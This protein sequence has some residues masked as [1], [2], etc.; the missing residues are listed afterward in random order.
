M[1]GKVGGAGDAGGAGDSGGYGGGDG[2]SGANGGK[3]F[4]SGSGGVGRTGGGLAVASL[5]RRRGMPKC[6]ASLISSF[7]SSR[8]PQCCHSCFP[9]STVSTASVKVSMATETASDVG[10]GASVRR[11]A[12]ASQFNLPGLLLVMLEPLPTSLLLPPLPLPPA[13]ARSAASM[14]IFA[15]LAICE[16]TATSRLA[17]R[18]SVSTGGSAVPSGQSRLRDWRAQ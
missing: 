13:W 1:G 4:G 16:L 6:T 2:G 12:S 15:A 11:R 5:C 17:T 7:I 3:E 14:P 8:R 18:S 10:G 9:P